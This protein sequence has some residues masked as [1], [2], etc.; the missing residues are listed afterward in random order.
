MPLPY[1][2]VIEWTVG[3]GLAQSSTTLPVGARV[4][5]CMVEVTSAYSA[6]GDLRIGQIGDESK[7]LAA[8]FVEMPLGTTSKRDQNTLASNP[9]KKVS[10]RV[11]GA[12][13]TG[14]AKVTVL[15]VEQP[16]P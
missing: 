4:L 10:A 8:E 14:Q 2:Q 3:T 5:S 13:S 1:V 15:Y 12:P 6:G 11:I 16:R 7:F 9:A